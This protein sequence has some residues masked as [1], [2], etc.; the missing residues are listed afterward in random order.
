MD[1]S[2]PVIN[3]GYSEKYQRCTAHR[4]ERRERGYGVGPILASP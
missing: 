1:K 2:P 3:V 4:T